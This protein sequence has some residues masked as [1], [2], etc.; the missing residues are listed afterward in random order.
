MER[1]FPS[2]QSGP[3][4]YKAL[5]CAPPPPSVHTWRALAAA[6]R[7]AASS[8]AEESVVAANPAAAPLPSAMPP[9]STTAPAATAG[10]RL[11]LSAS[12]KRQQSA[13]SAP[14]PPP[15]AAPEEGA[16]AV[17]PASEAECSRSLSSSATIPAGGIG[18][19]GRGERRSVE[20]RQ[21]AG[22]IGRGTGRGGR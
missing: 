12:R 1:C 7:L 18:G 14:P 4:R 20:G 15:E 21:G 6:F 2:A 22:F 8:C 5:P 19:G 10:R 9:V 16:E 3:S 17:W 11:R 13:M